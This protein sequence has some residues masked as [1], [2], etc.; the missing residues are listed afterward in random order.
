MEFKTRPDGTRAPVA[1]S[2]SFS[3]RQAAMCFVEELRKAGADEP[4]LQEIELP[5][6]K[7]LDIK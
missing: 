6:R 3:S 5:E 4:Y 7:E 1:A 2:R